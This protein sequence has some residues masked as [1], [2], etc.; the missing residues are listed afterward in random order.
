MYETRPDAAD[1]QTLKQR[2]V[3]SGV[4]G[5]SPVYVKL[6]DY[7]LSCAEEGRQPKEFE[8]AVDVL[9]RDSSFDVTRD[10]VVRVYIHQLRKRL[11]KYYARIEPDA[12]Y[13]IVIP[14]GQY[15]ITLEA[16]RQ[17]TPPATPEDSTRRT[18]RRYVLPLTA[19]VLLLLIGNVWQ[20]WHAARPAA[21]DQISETLTH[22]MWQQL[23]DDELPILLVMGDYYIFGELD[24]DGRV[25]RMVRD[26]FINSSEDLSS[27]FMQD[28]TLQDYF[29]D[30]DMSYMPEGSAD[31]ML[32]IAPILRASG[33]RVRVTMMSRLKTSDLRDNHIVYIGYISALDKLNN[34]YFQTSGLL[35]GRTFD[36]LYV[37]Q[38][39]QLFTSTAG[40]PQQGQPF[41]DLALLA[42]WPGANQN[43]FVLITGTRDAGLMHAAHVAASLD[44]LQT[45]DNADT[46]NPVT[47]AI[48]HEALFE[49]YGIDRMNF[50][51]N[52]LYHQP[53][54]PALIWA[55]SQ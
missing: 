35:P 41:R 30:L 29:R 9:D 28:S 54:D 23:V 2:I 6:L 50:E 4:L 45:L 39:Q 1:L 31:A 47:S 3:D 22:P 25:N 38:S 10:S 7:L 8:I 13:R 17:D 53:L 5:R 19:L 11:E 52:L 46:V 24:E 43:Q 27:L 51:A 18:P 33:K 16:K 36:E 34:L 55:S 44:Q 37:K 49:V 14:K 21:L 42:T 48:S 32:Q 26:F 15:I 40:L 12:D 20:W